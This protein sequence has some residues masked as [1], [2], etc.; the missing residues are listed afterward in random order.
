MSVE[1]IISHPMYSSSTF[2]NDIALV[3][4]SSPIQF[5]TYVKPVCLPKDGSYVPVGTKCFVTG[6]IFDLYKGNYHGE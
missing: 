1:R 2:N 4:L 6:K 3:K 5:G